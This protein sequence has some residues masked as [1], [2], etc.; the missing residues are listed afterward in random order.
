MS[1]RETIFLRYCDLDL[2][3]RGLAT[4]DDGRCCFEADIIETFTGQEN[5]MPLVRESAEIKIN[6]MAAAKLLM[7]RNEVDPDAARED[8]MQRAF[9]DGAP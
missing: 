8:C 4:F 9:E 7:A 2:T 3:V 6:E 5:I 1:S